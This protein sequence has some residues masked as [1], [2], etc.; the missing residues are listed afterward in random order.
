MNGPRAEAFRQIGTPEPGGIVAVCDHASNV[1]PAD[2]DLGISPELL[3]KHI[4]WDIGAAGVTER[5]ARDHGIPAHLG[6]VSRLVC[7]FNRA[8]DAPGL[9][10]HASDGHAIPGNLFDLA[11][12]ED[13][14]ERFYRPYHDELA[15]WLAAARPAL[16]LSIHSFTPCLESAPADRPWEIGILYNRDE[17]AARIGIPL[18]AEAGCVVGDNEPYSGK[19]LN[20]TMNR[21]AEGN[22]WPYLGIE[23]R[24]DLIGDEAGQARWA[25]LV[26]DVARKVAAALP[27][28]RN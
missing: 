20:A 21:H 10:P 7:D 24:Q 25:E 16:V 4:A 8:E 2:I 1:V 5:L 28:P 9:V 26:A 13:R 22:G 19:T 23:I 17:R 15:R 6:A 27:G 11:G 18:L 14:V 3:T 12:R